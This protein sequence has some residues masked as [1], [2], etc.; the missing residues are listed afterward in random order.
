MKW[1]FGIPLLVLVSA[2]LY[3]ALP[4]GWGFV[5]DVRSGFLRAVLRCGYV[6]LVLLLLFSVGRQFYSLLA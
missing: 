3:H 5:S 6:L 2:M 4:I 1:L